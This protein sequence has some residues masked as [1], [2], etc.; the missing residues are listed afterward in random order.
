MDKSTLRKWKDTLISKCWNV[1]LKIYGLIG[2][3]SKRNT[4][5]INIKK[6]RKRAS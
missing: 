5:K 3:A 1:L 4:I 2:S 6:K